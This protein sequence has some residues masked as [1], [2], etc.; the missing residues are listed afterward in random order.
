MPS[1]DLPI[2]KEISS[3]FSYKDF[4]TISAKKNI[5]TTYLI[6]FLLKQAYFS[7]WIFD[8]NDISNKDDIFISNEITRN[9]VLTLLNKEI[10][11]NII[12]KN[13]IFKYLKNGDLKIKQELEIQNNRYKKIIIG[14]NGSKIRDLRIKSQ[15]IISKTFNTNT[16]LYINVIT[17]NAKKI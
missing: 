7:K 16:H 14:R 4:F 13:L 1:P 9:Q 6:K 8:K 11:Y 15:K 3:Y 17:K 10:P 12:V 5:G 2:I